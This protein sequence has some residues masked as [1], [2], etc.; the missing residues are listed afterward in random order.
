MFSEELKWVPDKSDLDK[1]EDELKGQCY[2]VGGPGK[3]SIKR[4]YRFSTSHYYVAIALLT[5]Y[6][7]DLPIFNFC[8]FLYYHWPSNLQ[9]E[10]FFP[11][12]H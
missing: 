11:P 5:T 2:R 1:I 6:H 3:S 7:W 8:P 9:V 12:K 4:F 10:S